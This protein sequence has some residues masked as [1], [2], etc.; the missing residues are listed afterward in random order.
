[1]QQRIVRRF[2]LRVSVRALGPGQ[3]GP[4]GPAQL[5]DDG[6]VGVLHHGVDDALRVDHHLDVVVA[7]AEQVVRL[8]DL[9]G[10]GQLGIKNRELGI[11]N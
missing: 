4:G 10:R 7:L 8:D 6:G 11:S 3:G 1:M 9:P 2:C 5:G